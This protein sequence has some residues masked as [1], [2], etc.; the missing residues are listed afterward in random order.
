MTMITLTGRARTCATVMINSSR[1]WL[2][3]L[4]LLPA[5][6]FC[7]GPTVAEKELTGAA[8]KLINLLFTG[9]VRNILLFF[10]LGSGVVGS[11][12][13]GSPK[14]F[15]VSITFGLILFLAPKVLSLLQGL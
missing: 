5:I 2:S 14:P 4:L 10:A 6:G 12:L 8:E 3:L 9:A 13:S 7:D 1:M 11:V 15:F